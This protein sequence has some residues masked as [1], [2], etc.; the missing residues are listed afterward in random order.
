M[1]NCKNFKQIWK[2]RSDYFRLKK[3]PRTVLSKICWRKPRM[4]CLLTITVQDEY[5]Y[6]CS[7][8]L[9]GSGGFNDFPPSP[10]CESDSLVRLWRVHSSKAWMQYTWDE[11]W[12]SVLFLMPE[13][14]PMHSWF[15][16]LFP[17]PQSCTRQ[18]IS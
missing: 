4:N 8:F 2:V 18:I 10:G 15:W 1:K 3:Q 9:L 14:I 7:M 11:T 17:C 5:E 13:E 6:A 12:A 16:A